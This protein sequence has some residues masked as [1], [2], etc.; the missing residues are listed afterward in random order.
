HRHEYRFG[1]TGTIAAQEIF[2][3]PILNDITIDRIELVVGNAPTSTDTITVDLQRWNGS[4][5]ASILSSTVVFNSSDT[6]MTRKVATISSGAINAT[7]SL[8]WVINRSGSSGSNLFGVARSA[9]S[10]GV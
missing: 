1:I 5:W 10:G 6:A 3:G 8:K 2:V 4:T 7:N 9:E